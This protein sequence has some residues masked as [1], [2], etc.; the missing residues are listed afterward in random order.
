VSGR[1]W[2]GR[3]DE[4]GNVVRTRGVSVKKA[5]RRAEKE[6]RRTEARFRCA[7]FPLYGLPPS[8][9]GDRFLGGAGWGGEPGHVKTLNL[10][11]VHGT[12]VQGEGPTLSVE[13]GTR[14][15]GGDLLMH[16]AQMTWS[17]RFSTVE[18]ATADLVRRYPPDRHLD[19]PSPRRTDLVIS[20]DGV[21]TSFDT[22][23]DGP[24]WVSRAHLG[25][26]LLTLVGH[27]FDPAEV[28]LVRITDLQPYIL[29]TRRFYADEHTRRHESG[30]GMGE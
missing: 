2:Y 24:E 1:A 20:V 11:L 29:G 27:P 7:P 17:G 30:L 14:P 23:V 5:M 3:I 9:H 10:S 28:A 19:L 18:E 22:F 4:K 6:R 26:N 25:P 12:L 16:L 8:S 15:G 13:T 21:Q